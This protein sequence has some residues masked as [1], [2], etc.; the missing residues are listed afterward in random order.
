MKN[1]TQMHKVCPGVSVG[2]IEYDISD[3]RKWNPLAII[4]RFLGGCYICGEL[5]PSSG[6]Y[7]ANKN[8][9][10]C[11]CCEG[12]YIFV[13]QPDGSYRDMSS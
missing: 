5:K 4:G 9:H 2:L 13:K 10:I 11:M 1:I 8:H 6:W 3:L 12:K 7:Q